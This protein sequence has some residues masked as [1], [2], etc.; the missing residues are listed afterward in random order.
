MQAV[1]RKFLNPAL[2]SP[3]YE[4]LGSPTG[5]RGG[6][7]V[8][9]GLPEIYSIF[10]NDLFREPHTGHFPGG[11]PSTVNPHTLQIW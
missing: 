5:R 4:T 9:P 11:S 8:G 7:A 2:L 10:L 1:N 6:A 3:D